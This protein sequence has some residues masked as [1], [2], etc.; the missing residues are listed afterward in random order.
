MDKF[1]LYYGSK[2]RVNVIN[3]IPCI[4]CQKLPCE[5]CHVISKGAGGTWRDIV[6]MCHQHHLLQHQ[7]GNITFSKRFNIDLTIKAIRFSEI[8]P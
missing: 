3:N 5:N 2:E 8:L 4:I 7:L 1:E 6:P